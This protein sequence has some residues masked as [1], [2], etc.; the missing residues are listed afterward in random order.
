M[1]TVSRVFILFLV[2]AIMFGCASGISTQN[3]A[4]QSSVVIYTKDGSNKQGIVLKRD[5]NNL[6][7]IDSETHN[8][9]SIS[10][11]NIIKLVK[12]DVIYDFE[13]NPIPRASVEARKGTNS[14]LL[15][16]GGGLVLG[17]AAGIGVG[18]ALVGAG[19]DV[20]PIISGAVFGIAG[21]WYFGSIGS[22]DDFDD[23]VFAVRQQRY[24][25]SK[26]KREKE[27]Q[28]EKKKIEAQKK[29]KEEL[30]KKLKE[31]KSQ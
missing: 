12:A 4:S 16:G 8:K 20:P 13:A 21:A 1:N 22:D 6:I 28:E 29:E 5:G 25:I 27:I 11:D 18:I 14:M 2:S 3:P 24:Q 10:Y 9:E 31:K 17:A 30:L 7:Y 15:Y 26:Q 19:A 23:A